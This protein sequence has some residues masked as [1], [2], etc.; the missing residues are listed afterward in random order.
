MSQN[1]SPEKPDVVLQAALD[2]EPWYVLRTRSNFEFKARDYLISGNVPCYL[3]TIS[4]RSNRDSVVR[5]LEKPA[6][7]GYLFVSARAYHEKHIQVLRM[8]GFVM[9]LKHAGRPEGVS[10]AVVANLQKVLECGKKP[11]AYPYLEKGQMV[12]VVKGALKGAFGFFVNYE[13]TRRLLVITLHILG[14]SIAVRVRPD[15]VM[16]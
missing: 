6:F 7:S 4:Q 14:R 5:I 10:N 8:P 2:S 16:V 13:P 11:L 12:Q 9:V 15:E 3:P 1:K